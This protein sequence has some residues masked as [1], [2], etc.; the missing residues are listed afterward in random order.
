MLAVP[1]IQPLNVSSETFMLST[2]RGTSRSGVR[3]DIIPVLEVVALRICIRSKT[4]CML[5]RNTPLG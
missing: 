4:G 1:V 2:N 3:A 5:D